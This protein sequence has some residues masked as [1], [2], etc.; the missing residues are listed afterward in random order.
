MYPSLVDM[1]NLCGLE[2]ELVLNREKHMRL[3]VGSTKELLEHCMVDVGF[4]WSEC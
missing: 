3:C 2:Q 1:G 4:S